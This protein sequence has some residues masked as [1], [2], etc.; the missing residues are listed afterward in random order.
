MPFLSVDTDPCGLEMLRVAGKPGEDMPV[1]MLD[2]IPQKFVVQLAGYERL[3]DRA[4]HPPHGLGE[5]VALSLGKVVRLAGVHP[6]K[7][8]AVAMVKLP[9]AKHG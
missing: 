3:A 6:G 4:R 8:H 7:H 2:L 5:S 1:R 9:P